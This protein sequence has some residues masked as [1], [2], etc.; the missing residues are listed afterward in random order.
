M[1]RKNRWFVVLGVTVLAFGLLFG[2]AMADPGDGSADTEGGW[3]MHEQMDPELY[4]QMIQHMTEVHG[5]EFTAEMLQRMNEGDGCHGAG[6]MNPA[7]GSMMSQS[8]DGTVAGFMRGVLGMAEGFNRDGM[9][10][11]GYGNGGGM[12][13]R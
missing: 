11:R 7:Y 1:F 8:Y 13:G 10:G 3:H 12:M 4:A 2:T 5:A 6:M 9:M